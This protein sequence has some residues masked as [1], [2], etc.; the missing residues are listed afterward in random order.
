VWRYAW[1]FLAFFTLL[2]AIFA[3]GRWSGRDAE[4]DKAHKAA[5][6]I[7][8]RVIHEAGKVE[9]RII[10]RERTIRLAGETSVVEI[11]AAPGASDPIQADV[12]S[13]WL[14][15]LGRVRQAGAD[16]DPGR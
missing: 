6:V 13:A 2:G 1:R 5:D 10:E 12:R 3:A 7:R 8:E 11:Q 14:A 16:P 9:T 15:G 4:R